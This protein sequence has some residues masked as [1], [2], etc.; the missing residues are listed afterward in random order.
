MHLAMPQESEFLAF[1]LPSWQLVTRLP[2]PA[3]AAVVDL[4]IACEGASCRTLPPECRPMETPTGAAAKTL[5]ANFPHTPAPCA[6]QQFSHTC[7]TRHNASRQNEAQHACTLHAG[8]KRVLFTHDDTPN[9]W[10]HPLAQSNMDS[11]RDYL[12]MTSVAF[13]LDYPFPDILAR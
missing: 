11:W 10:W 3:G 6:L 4:L 13:V 2:R 12:F 7:Q 1:L 8:G 9:C 5:L